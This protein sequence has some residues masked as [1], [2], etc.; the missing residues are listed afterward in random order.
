[1]NDEDNDIWR[2]GDVVEITLNDIEEGDLQTDNR[3]LL[4]VNSNEELFEFRE[5]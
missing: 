3:L 1:V 2:P 4:T 5:P